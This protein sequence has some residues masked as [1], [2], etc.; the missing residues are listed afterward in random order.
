LSLLKK[1]LAHYQ[2][3]KK[4]YQFQSITMGGLAEQLENA[5]G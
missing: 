4:Q 5:N 3:L 2:F 1:V